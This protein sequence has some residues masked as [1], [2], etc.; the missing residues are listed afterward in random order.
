[1]NTDQENAPL[2]TIY[3]RAG[4]SSMAQANRSAG[5][6]ENFDDARGIEAVALL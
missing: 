2:N 4:T 3:L 6:N 1:M 5:T